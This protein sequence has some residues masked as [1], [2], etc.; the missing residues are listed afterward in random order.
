MIRRDELCNKLEWAIEVN[1]DN[2]RLIKKL[3]SIFGKKGL[4]SNLPNQIFAETQE[5]DKLK[6]IELMTLAEALTLEKKVEISLKDYCS[7]SELIDYKTFKTKVEPLKSV[8]FPNVVQ[9]SPTQWICPFWEIQDIYNVLE[10]KLIRYNYETQ[11]SATYITKYGRT[12]K[13]PTLNQ[14]ATEEISD[15]FFANRFTP[16]LI[17]FNI[18]VICGKVPNFEF[19]KTAD[20]THQLVITPSFDIDVEKTTSLD[21]TDGY[22]RISG[23]Y[24]AM[25]RALK[26]G[27]ELNGG[28]IVSITCMTI[29]DAQEYVAREFKRS[30][31]NKKYLKALENNEYKRFV[32]LLNNTGNKDDNILNNNIAKDLNELKHGN[33][34]TTYETMI[35]ALKQTDIDLSVEFMNSF[36]A[37]E[38]TKTI[39]GII[40]FIKLQDLKNDI[41]FQNNMFIGYT[42][43]AHKIGKLPVDERD[44]SLMNIVYK[45]IYTNNDVWDFLDIRNNNKVQIKKISEYFYGLFD[46]KKES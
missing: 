45:I 42:L 16:N 22:H 24:K 10:S 37:E 6:D 40:K 19:I 31:T 25:S 12:K 29:E 3:T 11:R 41:F 34:L 15:E 46:N 23:A 1:R 13:V 17:T 36:R 38:F 14:V 33:K 9:I 27:K 7:A 43:I 35:N 2:R 32:E 8:V 30:D 21:I 28:L 20:G 4:A 18:P 26:E 44:K 5:I 39:T